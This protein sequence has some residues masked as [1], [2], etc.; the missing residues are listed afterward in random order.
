MKGKGTDESKG[1]SKGGKDKQYNEKFYEVP[2]LLPRFAGRYGY[3][4][5]YIYIYLLL[6]AVYTFCLLGFGGTSTLSTPRLL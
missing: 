3:T 1:N 2:N 5:I 4:Y 6:L